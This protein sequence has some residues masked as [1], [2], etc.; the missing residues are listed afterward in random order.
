MAQM[1]E[2]ASVVSFVG[3]SLPALTHFQICEA[4]DRVLPENQL[5]LLLAFER[6]KNKELYNYAQDTDL[7]CVQSMNQKCHAHLKYMCE[8]DQGCFPLVFGDDIKPQMTE[9]QM[10][11]VN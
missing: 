8:N 3:R 4:L 2:Q 5:S 10:V 9:E 11:F 1:N 7:T 6:A